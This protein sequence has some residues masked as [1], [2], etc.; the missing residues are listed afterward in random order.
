[1]TINLEQATVRFGDKTALDNFTGEFTPG[2]VTALIGGDGAGK[3]TLLKLLAGRLRT[4]S[5]NNSGYAVDR[6]NVGYQPAESGVWRHL[7]VA[8]NIEFVARTYGLS[9]DK[10]RTRSEELLTKAGLDHVPNRLAGRLSGGM[11]QKLGVVL[12]TLHQPGLVLLDE[13]TTG[14][15]PI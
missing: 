9:P 4:H 13:P 6:H 15:D 11:R 1:M 7:S 10:A 2:T 12:A 5:G 8:E 3:T 14:V